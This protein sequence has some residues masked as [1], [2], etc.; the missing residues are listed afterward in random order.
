MSQRNF[1]L[2]VIVTLAALFLLAGCA[3]VRSTVDADARVQGFTGLFPEAKYVETRYAGDEALAFKDV[4]TQDCGAL[5]VPASYTRATYVAKVAT[6]SAY[7]SNGSVFCVASKLNPDVFIVEKG[8][9]ASVAQ[10]TLLTVNGEPVTVA[11]VNAAY[12]L[13]NP[14]VRNQTA[15]AVIVNQL[16][17]HALLR[18]AAK[19]LDV[20]Q[21]DV[22]AAAAQSWKSLGYE[23]RE[24][25]EAALAAQNATYGDFLESVT[26]QV[27]VNELLE[28]EGVTSVDVTSEEAKSYYL[29]NP[30]TFLVSEQV[31]FRQL[32][33]DFAKNG[34]Q[35]SS[36]ERLQE[37][38]SQLESGLDYCTAVKR[39]SDDKD[40]KERCGEYVAPR[41]VLSPDLEASIFALQANQSAV[42]ASQ[43]GYHVISVLAH[44]PTTVIPYAQAEQQVVGLLKNAVVQQRL[45]IYLLK[46]RAD[47]KIVDYTMQ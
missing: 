35:E 31:R 33:L 7:V 34:G 10:G 3:S 41:G 15:L 39:Y 23:S 22:D 19:H 28:R 44:Q 14:A 25:F 45:N 11:Q 38:L 46:L 37:I 40:S 32:Y 36:Q 16:V 29:A 27:R 42:V 2:I 30:N 4:V 9:P 12:A 21:A 47:A 8:D 24:L 43:N 1:T 5:P 18:Q 26:A 6:L 17:D 13:L 20:S